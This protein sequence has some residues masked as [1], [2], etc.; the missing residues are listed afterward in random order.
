MFFFCWK[1]SLQHSRPPPPPPHSWQKS[2]TAKQWSDLSLIRTVVRINSKSL[3]WILSHLFHWCI[4][5][6]QRFI[7]H[8]C[9]T[10]I[11]EFTSFERCNKAFEKVWWKI[12]YWKLNIV[13]ESFRTFP[14]PWVSEQVSSGS[15]WTVFGRSAW[16]C[17]THSGYYEF[18]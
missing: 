1:Q 15:Q 5:C 6:I 14:R 17:P 11:N 10:R 12:E 9:V 2:D 8:I 18:D 16:Q 13:T 7:L 3:L 4:K